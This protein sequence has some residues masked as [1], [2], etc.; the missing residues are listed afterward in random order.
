MNTKSERSGC[1]VSS[2]VILVISAAGW[3][4]GAQLVGFTF[5]LIDKYPMIAITV[6]SILL[7]LLLVYAAIRLI[8]TIREASNLFNELFKKD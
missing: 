3:I 7:I 5:H 8:I 4:A 1:I 2:L 6:F